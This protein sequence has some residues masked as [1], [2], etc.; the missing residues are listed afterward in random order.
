VLQN[1]HVVVGLDGIANE[2]TG[3]ESLDGLLVRA[4]VGIELALAC[5]VER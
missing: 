2:G 1:G 5:Q 4:K 3:V